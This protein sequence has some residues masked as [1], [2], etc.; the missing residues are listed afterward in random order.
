MR[1]IWLIPLLVIALIGQCKAQDLLA[2]TI[3]IEWLA[4]FTYEASVDLYTRT[5]ANIDHQKIL[6]NWGDGLTDTLQSQ[7]AGIPIANDVSFYNY[8]EVHTYPGQG[9]YTIYVQD[10]FRIDSILN[11]PNSANEL[12]YLENVLIIDVAND[13]NNS[14]SLLGLLVDFVIVSQPAVLNISAFDTNGDS[15]TYALLPPSA[16][17]SSIPTG[18]TVDPVTGDIT[19]DAPQD[20]GDIVVVGLLIEEWRKGTPN[21]TVKI[22]S[23]ITELYFHVIYPTGVG[24]LLTEKEMIVYPNPTNG[25]TTLIDLPKE[26]VRIALYNIL[27]EKIRE[28]EIGGASDKSID[29]LMLPVG[30]YTLRVVQNNDTLISKRII[31]I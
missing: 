24:E 28:W 14:P 6:L 3:K 11:I 20:L 19:W 2:G 21:G 13:T 30:I 23:S 8:K 22:G 5:S 10:S 18:M 4:N 26:S 17:S 12:L 25:K 1:Q 31:K 9:A 15:L 7:S 27:G 16:T 29:L